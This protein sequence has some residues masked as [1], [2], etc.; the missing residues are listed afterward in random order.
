[1]V[2]GTFQNSHMN[3]YLLGQDILLCWL[4]DVWKYNKLPF[5]II[6]KQTH[7]IIL[8]ECFTVPQMYLGSSGS[9]PVRCLTLPDILLVTE[10]IASS[11]YKIFLH[12][13]IGLSLP[14]SEKEVLFFI[15]RRVTRFFPGAS[16]RIVKVPLQDPANSALWD[17]L[18]QLLVSLLKLSSWYPR[19]LINI[20]L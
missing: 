8:S 1:M 6:P 19:E 2:Y 18:Y 17:M 9:E 20:P 4:F 10:N 12:L 14:S 16:I 13:G 3:V 11:L 7:A 15:C 5:S